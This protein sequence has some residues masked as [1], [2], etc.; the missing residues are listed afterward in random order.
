MA[1]MTL[2]IDERLL[3]TA[4][5]LCGVKTKRETV[6]IAL[7]ELVQR[8]RRREMATHAGKVELELSQE[9]LRRLREGR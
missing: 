7:R 5:R 8:L 4:R 2:T 1:R 6:E 9:G 3:E